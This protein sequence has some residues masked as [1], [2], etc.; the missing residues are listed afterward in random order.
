MRSPNNS[1]ID[2]RYGDQLN[3]LW[4]FIDC[5]ASS[6]RSDKKPGTA[7]N[8]NYK[9]KTLLQFGFFQRTA[10]VLLLGL[11]LW[12]GTSHAARRLRKKPKVYNALITTDENLTSSRAYPVIQPTIHEP[13]YAPFGPYNPFGYYSP[14][15]VRFGQP[16]VPGLSPNE[17]VSSTRNKFNY[18][19]IIIVL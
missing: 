1:L 10:L 8:G 9:Y 6:D 3:R 4:F 11:V 2:C 19:I 16:I 14:P 18:N 17:R 12:A 7:V 15:L 5:V 13:G